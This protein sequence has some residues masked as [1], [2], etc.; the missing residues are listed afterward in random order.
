MLPSPSE[1]IVQGNGPGIVAAVDTVS[2]IDIEGVFAV[3]IHIRHDSHIGHGAP[4]SNACRPVMAV[5][6]MKGIIFR[7]GAA[8]VHIAAHPVERQV[9][10]EGA[11]LL[12]VH[13]AIADAGV[14]GLVIFVGRSVVPVFAEYAPVIAASEE[15]R[16]LHAPD[17][18]VVMISPGPEAGISRKADVVRVEIT[19]GIPDV[20]SFGLEGIH[21]PPGPSQHGGKARFPFSKAR[22]FLFQPRFHP[23]LQGFSP[24][25]SLKRKIIFTDLFFACVN[26]FL[27][28]C[29]GSQLPFRA[30]KERTSFGVLSFCCLFQLYSAICQ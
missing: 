30:K 1:N 23:V 24:V 22:R 6:R 25:S 27:W 5:Q 10:I 19:G 17:M 16:G 15:N 7:T 29:N 11:R 18:A 20:G 12:Q 9:H 2:G 13:M 21:I 4:E 28:G 14:P 8:E 3:E 26:H